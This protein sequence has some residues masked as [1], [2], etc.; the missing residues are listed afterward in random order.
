[1]S[2]N[3]RNSIVTNGL[4]LYLDAANRISYVSGSTTWNDLS[5]FNNNGT[6]VNGPTFNSA[7]GGTLDFDGTNDYVILNNTV[8]LTT[9]TVNTNLFY[10]YL[11]K[12]FEFFL[13][14]QTGG[15]QGKILL[16]YLG[17]VSFRNSLYYD[18]NKTSAS[19]NNKFSNLSFVSNSTTISLYVNGEFD[20]TITPTSTNIPISTIGTAWTDFAW[21]ASFKLGNI[22]IYNRA[23]SATEV[24]QNYNATK[25]R[26]GL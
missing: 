17:K 22:Q 9:W 24:L 12:T 8:S 18:F 21:L 16:S 20:S 19:L 1:M 15:G 6:L 5:G 14:D 25:T 7:N 11:S 23:L 4:V 2:V 26:F 10:N 3:T 13:G